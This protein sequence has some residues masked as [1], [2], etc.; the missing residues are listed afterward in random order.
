MDTFTRTTMRTVQSPDGSVQVTLTSKTSHTTY[1]I[2][3]SLLRVASSSVQTTINLSCDSLPPWLE[4]H[5]L[6]DSGRTSDQ[7]G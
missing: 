6:E 7:D 1:E 2:S 4:P 3:S 5:I